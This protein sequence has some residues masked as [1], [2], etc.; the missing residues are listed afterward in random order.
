[1]H[2]FIM[3]PVLI[4][5]LVACNEDDRHD[6]DRAENSCTEIIISSDI[7]PVHQQVT[8]LSA[9]ADEDGI[10]LKVG[11]SGCDL[12]RKID[13]NVSSWM[14]KTL[15]PQRDAWFS[16]PGQPCDGY[17]VTDL[18]FDREE[19]SEETKLRIITQTDTTILM[20]P[21]FD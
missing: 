20:L 14:L 19:I 1:M 4:F 16:F 5:G 3:I 9:E 8:I 6:C 15:P 21:E 17:F 10:V 13:L 11:I 2:K 7:D 18:C 12:S